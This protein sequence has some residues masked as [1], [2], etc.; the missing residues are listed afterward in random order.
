MPHSDIQHI[1]AMAIVAAAAFAIFK[2]LWRQGQAFQ[3]RPRRKPAT[4]SKPSAPPAISPLIQLQL[5]PPA[6]LKRPP[7]DDK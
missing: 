1:L 2:R 6:H 5:K 3:S 4:G 7:V